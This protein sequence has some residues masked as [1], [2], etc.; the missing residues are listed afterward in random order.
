MSWEWFG[1]K[2][3]DKAS[4]IE[5]FNQMAKLTAHYEKYEIG[6]KILIP[7]DI[8]EKILEGSRRLKQVKDAAAWY[9]D[10]KAV[11]DAV[12]ALNNKEVAKNPTVAGKAYGQFFS[13]MGAVMCSLPPPASGYGN[14]LKNVGV[15]FPGI[16]KTLMPSAHGSGL[17]SDLKD[18]L[19]GGQKFIN[20]I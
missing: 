18:F 4:L 8:H 12:H 13:A 15:A 17:D 3:V 10:M 6:Y 20:G 2:K 11:Y 19:A 9:D 16:V 5:T 1:Y 14:I 7:N